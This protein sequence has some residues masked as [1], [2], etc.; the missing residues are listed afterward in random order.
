MSA[1]T[2]LKVEKVP[3]SQPKMK[4]RLQIDVYEDELIALD[5]L[6]EATPTVHTRRELMM[7]ALALFKVAVE[8]RKLG[9]KTAF[10]NP[11]NPSEVHMPTF[12]TLD[13]ILPE[14][15]SVEVAALP[16]LRVMGRIKTENALKKKS[17]KS[18]NARQG[19]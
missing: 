11:E 19:G 5:S 9:R 17:K 18:S 10:L 14:E 3:L 1:K 4:K 15:V 6:L 7:N 12:F 2:T 16:T 13:N 8:Q